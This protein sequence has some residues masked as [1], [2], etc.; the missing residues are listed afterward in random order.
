LFVYTYCFIIISFFFFFISFSAN[1]V[2]LDVVHNSYTSYTKNVSLRDKILEA[3]REEDVLK[4]KLRELE[5]KKDEEK[6]G[7]G[8]EGIGYVDGAFF[9][10]TFF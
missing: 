4:E 6:H 2:S 10:F 9:F 5:K 1:S 7:Y 8:S 3:L